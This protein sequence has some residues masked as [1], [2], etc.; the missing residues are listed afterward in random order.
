MLITM[1]FRSDGPQ[2][3]IL[4]IHFVKMV[5]ITIIRIHL[6]FSLDES[7]TPTRI[8]F[9]AGTSYHDLIEFSELA[10]DQ[11]KGWVDVDL[12]GVGGGP[13]KNT[14][15]AFIV[16]MKILENH[17]NGKDTHVRGV[18]IYAQEETVRVD[19]LRMDISPAAED[20]PAPPVTA[21]AR[22]KARARAAAR[23]SLEA[24]YPAEPS[25]SLNPVLR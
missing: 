11:P 20:S 14:L 10:F 25:W 8:L 15:R 12:T 19:D 16:Q 5:N 1:D 2:P 24:Q 22:A 6:D 18:K 23:A 9:L 17:Q 13:D 3:H 7:Y 21:K 4:N